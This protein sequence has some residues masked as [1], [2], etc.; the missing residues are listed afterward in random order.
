MTLTWQ[1]LSFDQ[2]STATLYQFLRLRVEVFV[3]EQNCAYPDLDGKDTHPDSLHLLGLDQHGTLAAYARL[4]PPQLSYPQPSIGRVAIAEPFRGSGLGHG[5][6]Q[7]AVRQTQAAWPEQDI[8]IGAQLYLQ[9]FYEAH[10]FMAV[11][12]PYL[13]D[14]IPHIDMIKPYA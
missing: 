8:Q 11:S 7:E 9:P 1:T 14:E 2:L 3:V 12:G 4:L 5:L 13:E 10:G 6:I